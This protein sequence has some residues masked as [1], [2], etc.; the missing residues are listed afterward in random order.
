VIGR[1]DTGVEMSQDRQRRTRS[2]RTLG[3]EEPISQTPRDGRSHERTEEEQR[4][5]ERAEEVER[6]RLEEE[7]LATQLEIQ[8]RRSRI[9]QI[10]RRLQAGSFTP[11]S[12]LDLDGTSS[13]SASDSV[14][15]TS[16]S[17]RLATPEL[18]YGKSLKDHT[19]FMWQCDVN[20][21]RDPRQ[22]RDDASKVLYAMQYLRGEPRDRW[23]AQE[24]TV[25]RDQATWQ[26]FSDFLLDLIQ[27]PVNRQLNT[28]QKYAD[29]RQKP[30]QSVHAYVTYI[31]SLEEELEPY[32]EDQRRLHLL[33]TLRPELRT[34]ITSHQNIPSTRAD[35]I[36]LAA[37]LEENANASRTQHPGKP[38]PPRQAA[39][40]SNLN[41]NPN[42]IPV[43]ETQQKASVRT[44]PFRGRG[45][46]WRGAGAPRRGYGRHSGDLSHITCYT[47]GQRGHYSTSCTQSQSG[48]N[49]S[50]DTSKNG[51]P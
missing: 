37:R 22:F 43:G 17:V 10:Q 3:T 6:L 15:H 8:E 34:T 14:S 29:A 4:R 23:R 26:E 51:Q 47:C 46:T 25:G 32:S 20:F 35:L 21:R 50:V 40:R 45:S 49:T 39:P 16:S 18:Y 24:S 5:V 7:D 44:Y 33:T 42:A 41:P 27:N 30:N 13:R 36:A 28:A 2:G 38:M 31:E 48:V 12:D 11:D 9:E 19:N 1:R